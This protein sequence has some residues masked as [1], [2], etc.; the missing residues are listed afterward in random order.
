MSALGAVPLQP[1]LL[2][3]RQTWDRSLAQLP[4]T[5]SLIVCFL[6]FIIAAPSLIRE[7]ELHTLEILL[8]APGIR[9]ITVLI[10]KILL[11]VI[12]SLFA[13]V[14]MLVLVQVV[15][16]LYVKA[17]MAGFLL[18]M[19]LPILSSTLLGLLV[20]A[21]AR[22]QVQTVMASAI[23]FFCLLLLGGF[24]Y[25]A[26]ASS[27]AIQV[28]TRFVGLTFLVDPANAWFFGAEPFRALPLV[29]LAIQCVV[30][31]ALAAI[32]WQHKLR[33]I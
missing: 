27:S 21:L 5:F 18:F 26:E 19:A 10:G 20:S 25:P 2:Y 7:R 15:Y 8:G 11:P 14:I 9:G 28:I 4:M 24:L 22:S 33:G 6:A 17:D 1:A 13:A 12:V 23:Y 32:A 3:Y 30:Y 16:G 31:A 29:P